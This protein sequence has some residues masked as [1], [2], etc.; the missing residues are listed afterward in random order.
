MSTNKKEYDRQWYHKNKEKILERQAT[1][2]Y[3]E[4]QYHYKKLK[5]ERLGEETQKENLIFIEEN[6][7]VEHPDY[8]GYYGTKESR[9]FSNKGRYGAIRE[10][11]PILQKDNNG[12]YLISCGSDENGKRN[13]VLWHRFIAK[14]F[15]PNPNNLPEVNHWDEDKSN[16][17]VGNLEWSTHIDNIRHSLGKGRKGNKIFKVTNLKTGEINMIK[18]LTEWCKKEGISRPEASRVANKRGRKT[19][20]N[21]T[22][23]VDIVECEFK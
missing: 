1:P 6:G 10:L 22:F 11:K 14:I 17:R 5:T 4:K 9:V 19:L 2:E 7:L 3:R 23:T 20:K 8:P 12:Y 18:N 16:C 21:K 13:Q 15:I